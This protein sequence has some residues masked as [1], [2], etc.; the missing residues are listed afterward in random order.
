[1]TW[2]LLPAIALILALGCSPRSATAPVAEVRRASPLA[3]PSAAIP[4]APAA[5][6]PDPAN[7]GELPDPGPDNPFGLVRDAARIAAERGEERAKSLDGKRIAFVR[8]EQKGKASLWVAKADG[9]AERKVLDVATAKVENPN[10]GTVLAD[11]S[12]IFGLSFSPDGKEIY[13]QADGFG[14]SLVVYAADVDKGTARFV[15]DA[16]DY[17]VITRCRRREHVGRLILFEHRY[18]DPIPDQAVNWYFLRDD[19]GKKLGIIGPEPENVERFLARVCGLGKAPPAK[20][21]TPIPARLERESLRCG[22]RVIAYRPIALLDETFIDLF[23]VTDPTAAQDPDYRP[24]VAPLS[25]VES[26]VDSA[27]PVGAKKNP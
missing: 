3:A 27:C 2:K 25:L 19:H 9:S 12:A 4:A 18:F 23:H 15:S 5:A 20:P 6:A 26:I 17:S 11:T 24:D 22:D 8:V 13:F 1:M 10:S 16:N 7:A 21:R 14:T